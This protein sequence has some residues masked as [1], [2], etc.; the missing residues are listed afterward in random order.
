MRIDL[1]LNIGIYAK[2]YSKKSL[3]YIDEDS[4]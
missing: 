2:N 4:K 1:P 3:N